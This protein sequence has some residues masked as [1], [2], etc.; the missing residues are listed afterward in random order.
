MPT[1][2]DVLFWNRWRDESIDPARFLRLA[3]RFH[4]ANAASG[5]NGYL[6]S[7]LR[8]GAALYL[9]PAAEHYLHVEPD[10]L[11]HRF[12]FDGLPP[13]TLT[14]SRTA[15]PP[16]SA[17]QSLRPISMT[18]DR[19]MAVDSPTDHVLESQHRPR[20]W[21]CPHSPPTLGELTALPTAF[22]DD[23]FDP[24]ERSSSFEHLLAPAGAVLPST[25]QPRLRRQGRCHRRRF[26]QPSRPRQTA[27]RHLGIALDI[28]QRGAR[29]HRSRQSRP[30]ARADAQARPRRRPTSRRSS[31]DPG[32]VRFAQQTRVN[33]GEC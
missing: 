24:L 30:A 5:S 7:V 19:G 27:Q 28:H 33:S 23:I 21:G 17:S 8:P 25:K 29:H 12:D 9:Q 13:V 1:P 10:C 2:R 22:D 15:G 26:A 16:L 32:W 14:K 11:L 3:D 4:Q 18:I 20:R 31:G 6:D